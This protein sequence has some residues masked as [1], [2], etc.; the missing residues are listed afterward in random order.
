MSHLLA[1]MIIKYVLRTFKSIGHG[2]E[3]LQIGDICQTQTVKNKQGSDGMRRK[4]Q[5]FFK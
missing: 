3:N 2:T 4:E 1:K 5:H